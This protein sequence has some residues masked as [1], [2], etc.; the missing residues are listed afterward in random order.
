MLVSL[1]VIKNPQQHREGQ[2]DFHHWKSGKYDVCVHGLQL[3]IF[4]CYTAQHKLHELWYATM[5][6]CI[7]TFFVPN[8]HDRNLWSVFGAS[9]IRYSALYTICILGRN[10]DAMALE[11][12]QEGFFQEKELLSSI[13]KWNICPR[14]RRSLRNIVFY[15]RLTK[16][17]HAKSQRYCTLSLMN[18]FCGTFRAHHNEDLFDGHL[19]TC[20]HTNHC[21]ALF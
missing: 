3:N 11:L 15:L 16:R 21:E 17:R 2:T 14:L 1:S 20:S 8:R 12:K 18:L 7:Y 13:S 4:Y 6:C 10:K 5:R 19:I 9:L